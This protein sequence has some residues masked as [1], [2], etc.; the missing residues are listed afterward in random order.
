MPGRDHKLI[1][2]S[3]AREIEA[4][5]PLWPAA[6]LPADRVEAARAAASSLP[7]IF[8]WLML[9]TR[10]T[11]DDPRVDLLACIVDAPGA[12]LALGDALASSRSPLLEGARPLLSAWASPEQHPQRSC[13][14]RTTI[15]WLEWD[16][17]YSAPPLQLPFIDRRFW[18]DPT[19][20][21]SPPEELVAM[22]DDG[23][24]ATFGEPA[25]R[26]M[27]A[28][29][30]RLIT[31]L[32]PS[33]RALAATS[34]RPR[35]R[36]SA[37]LF[38]SVPR[39]LVLPW[40]DSIGWPGE[41]ARVRRWLPLVVA[42][43]E[44]VFLQIEVAD[45]APTAYLG[46]EPRQTELSTVDRRERAR[47]LTSLIDAG[48]TDPERVASLDAWTLGPAPI[49]ADPRTVRSIHLK[50]ILQPEAEVEVKA[51]FGLHLRG[52][53]PGRRASQRPPARDPRDRRLAVAPGGA[54][55]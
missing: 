12:R 38:I 10:L 46:L 42:P 55:E 54:D 49:G 5:R 32:P 9:E 36:S 29:F 51:Y 24:R 2:F 39:A 4:H 28:A 19:A 31:S 18:G 15:V 13:L 27:L 20:A 34:L 6:L 52:V 45:G 8:H 44:D 47:L 26:A 22:V 41:R 40:L 25:E 3:L 17:P 43:W 11:G 30:R 33:A 14:E 21:P 48:L 16:A 1:H 50:L 53:R 23:H 7:P 35:G 37:R